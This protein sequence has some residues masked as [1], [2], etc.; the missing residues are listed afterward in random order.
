MKVINDDPK[1][2]HPYRDNPNTNQEFVRFIIKGLFYFF[3]TVALLVVLVGG[4]IAVVSVAWRFSGVLLVFLFLG[5][6][7]YAF[8]KDK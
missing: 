1:Q 4:T 7:I 8:G 2:D 3:I 5:L 6:M